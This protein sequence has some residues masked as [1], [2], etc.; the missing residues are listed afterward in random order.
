MC[1]MTKGTAWTL[2][3]ARTWVGYYHQFHAFGSVS[4]EGG[5]LALVDAHLLA[6]HVCIIG[7]ACTCKGAKCQFTPGSTSH[8]AGLLHRQYLGL[9]SQLTACTQLRQ[10]HTNIK[11]VY[12][13]ITMSASILQHTEVNCCVQE[14]QCVAPVNIS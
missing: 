14:T 7:N 5:S 13:K 11:L 1:D 3:I 12:D 2:S 9:R 10:G 6:M 8:K 4:C